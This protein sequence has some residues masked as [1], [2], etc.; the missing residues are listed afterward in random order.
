MSL[1]KH[2]NNISMLLTYEQLY[3]QK[4]QQHKQLI[5]EQSTGEH[6][7]LHQLI[8]ETSH[9]S[10]PKRTTDQYPSY[11]NQFHPDSAWKRSHQKPGM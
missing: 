4:R 11:Q 3:I 8:H 10:Y 9:T 1:L 6:N 2:I 5:L 7:P